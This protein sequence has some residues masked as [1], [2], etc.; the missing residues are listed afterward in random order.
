M[1]DLRIRKL[2]R[3]LV[4]YSVGVKKE[5]KVLID[6]SDPQGLALAKEVYQQVF[7]KK[8]RPFLLLGT[9]DLGPFYFK[10]AS[11]KQ[12]KQK[13]EVLDFIIDW[14]DKSIRIKAAKNDRALAN[15][16]SERLI[17][18]QKAVRP[19][20]DKILKKPWVLTYYPTQ[21][22][23]QSA[24]MSLDELED[25]YFK[26][27]LQDWGQIS[28]QAAKIKKIMDNAQKIRVLGEKTDLSFSLKGRWAKICDGHY[29]LP[30]GE[31]YAAPLDGTTSGRIYFDFPSLRDGKEVRDIFLG[32]KKGKVIK[33]SASKNQEFLLKALKTDPGA[34]RPGEFS[35]GTNYG[36]TRFIFNTL[37]DEK[38]G[39]TTHLALGRSYEE[40]EGG[41]KNKSAIHWDLVK[42]MRKKDSQVII[43]K[44]TVLKD[45][46]ITL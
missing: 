35:F 21:S 30:D 6:C 27:C 10:K 33:A 39:G 1:I 28:A 19:V 45:G 36:I 4:D 2:A 29:N 12:L 34:S 5:E 7:L 20:L 46:K 25:F 11:L 40:K 42:D 32:F 44:T 38:I 26:A 22:M 3:I 13:P 31:V 18:R 15:I 8:A 17:L 37:F 14:M 41:G 9:E 43:D 24:S 16:K 23:A